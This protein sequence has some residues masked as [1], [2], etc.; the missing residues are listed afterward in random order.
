[1]KRDKRRRIEAKF[2]WRSYKLLR[3]WM[4]EQWLDDRMIGI[5]TSTHRSPCSCWACGNRR[6]AEGPPRQERIENEKWN[7]L[8]REL[9]PVRSWPTNQWI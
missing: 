4:P 2:K 3:R 8:L 6:R 5:W 7:Q 1:M 9:G